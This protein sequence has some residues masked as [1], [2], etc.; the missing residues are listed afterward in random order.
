MKKLIPIILLVPFLSLFIINLN[1]VNV[2]ELPKQ[3][4]IS[5]SI[6][7]FI[8]FTSICFLS[9]E[10]IKIKKYKGIYFFISLWILSLFIS[11]IFGIAPYKSFFGDYFR[12]SGVLSHL[13]YILY[14][15]IVLSFIK[16]KKDIEIFLLGILII[17]IP[18][19][20]HAILQKAG[21]FLIFS[22][23]DLKEAGFLGRSYSTFGNPNMLGQY[24]IFPI[25]ISFYFFLEKQKKLKFLLLFL[26]LIIS[27]LFTENRASLLGISIGISLYFFFAKNIKNTTKILTIALIT[28]LFSS[29]IYAFSPSLRSFSSRIELWKSGTKSFIENPIFG[30][31]FETF[32]INFQK[33][34]TENYYKHEPL[35]HTADRA[36]NEIIDIQSSLGIYGF[37]IYF[38]AILFLIIKFLYKKNKNSLEKNLIFTLIALQIS[39]F[40]SFSLT[41]NF[42]TLYTI[43][44]LS[45]ILLLKGHEKNIKLSSKNILIIPIFLIISG[46]ISLTYIKNLNAD[47]LFK[48]FQKNPS[49]EKINKAM[50][51][52]QNQSIIF[53][54][55]AFLLKQNNY[56]YTDYLEKAGKFENKSYN[57]Y[58]NKARLQENEEK[59]EALKTLIKAEKLAPNNNNIFFLKGKLYS[60]NKEYL[61]SINELSKIIANSTNELFY[62]EDTI[63]KNRIK[64]EYYFRK[65]HLMIELLDLQKTN[66][67]KIGNLKESKYYNSLK[68]LAIK[69]SISN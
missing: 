59:D 5:I 1:G 6:T 47:I 48:S 67:E 11:T 49:L 51:L 60:E 19:S 30:T 54:H 46:L 20:I 36:H 65:N 12:L 39:N 41:L 61:K 57:Y 58:I 35:F 50:S 18:L 23:E 33:N 52:N 13:L 64:Y 2:Y 7:I 42:L 40:F 22:I 66:F 34:I 37:I 29:Y 14:F 62:D 24:L 31:G 44:A 68:Q 25:F 4:F 63:K 55:T 3:A 32:D 10:K 56:D 17:S 45:S 21:F 26:L 53:Y 28:T 38:S 27:I 69:Y 16:N 15:L 43:I 9:K 8:I